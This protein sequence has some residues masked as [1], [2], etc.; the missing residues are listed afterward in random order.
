VNY[1]S[2]AIEIVYFSFLMTSFLVCNGTSIQIREYFKSLAKKNLK[3]K[4]PQKRLGKKNL[5]SIKKK[6][7]LQSIKKNYN[8]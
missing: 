5:Q 3:L 6:E 4:T 1:I 2:L 7:Y 8:P